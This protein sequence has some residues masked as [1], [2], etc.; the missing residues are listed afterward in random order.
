MNDWKEMT[1]MR[2]ETNENDH[3]ACFSVMMSDVLSGTV[4]ERRF[5]PR[6]FMGRANT[7]VFPQYGLNDSTGKN[8][9]TGMLQVQAASSW[10]SCER[11]VAVRAHLGESRQKTDRQQT[12]DACFL[13]HFIAL[14]VPGWM[15]NTHANLIMG[16]IK[17][18]DTRQQT[19][20]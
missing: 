5:T 9:K 1:E 14:F 6:L 7:S 3:A 17:H 2:R 20:S 13:T 18:S 8:Q 12:R 11:S 10:R 16:V 19:T 15:L 4:V